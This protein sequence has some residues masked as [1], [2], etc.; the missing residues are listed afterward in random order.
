MKQHRDQR[1]IH[2][3]LLTSAVILNKLM[4]HSCGFC[5]TDCACFHVLFSGHIRN[6]FV[7]LL[8]NLQFIIFEQTM[9]FPPYVLVLL[10]CKFSSLSALRNNADK[11]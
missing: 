2:T 8:S 3:I 1:K 10:C 11:N 7:S 9:A 5:L 6:P 4:P